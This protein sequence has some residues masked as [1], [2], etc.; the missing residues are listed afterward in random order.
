MSDRDIRVPATDDAELTPRSEGLMLAMDPALSA[1]AATRRARRI[2]ADTLPGEWDVRRLPHSGGLYQALRRQPSLQPL[3]RGVWELARRVDAHPDVL[4]AE[5]AVIQPGHDADPARVGRRGPLG[6]GGDR[7]LPCSAA[8]EWSLASARLAEA[9]SLMPGP[10]GRGIVVAH[11]DTGYT[12]H[13]EILD[14]QRLAVTL[15]YDFEADRRDPRD[16]LR[17]RSPGHGTA[18]A[19]VIMSA[20]GSADGEAGEEYE[21]GW[22]SGA[23]PAATLIP[24]RVSSGVVHFSF[25]RLALAIDHAI[26]ID[27]RDGCD[28]I[29]MSLGGPFASRSL[30]MMIGAAA[31]RGIIG[32]AAA[33]NVWPWVV[34][35]ARMP[36]VIAVAASNCRDEIWRYS[37]AGDEVDL[38]APGQDV[39]RALAERGGRYDEARSSGTSYAVATVA[40]AAALWLSRHGRDRLRRL[41]PG[42]ALPAVFRQLLTGPGVRRPP[43]WDTGRHGAG[44]LDAVGLLGARLPRRGPSSARR[45]PAAGIDTRSELARYFPERDAGDIETIIERLAG[46]GTDT[47]AFLARYGDELRFHL[48]TSPAFRAA[49]TRRGPRASRRATSAVQQHLARYASPALRETLPPV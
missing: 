28:V 3:V 44:I 23:A 41:Y 49:L 46:A 36:G 29:S 33:G 26:C 40:G 35:P 47:E 13:P 10:P 24:L 31:E 18:T 25:R 22:V 34:H 39:W 17:G 1:S 30:E 2:V 42:A 14:P 32:L 16:P 20:L 9:F 27:T 19:S 4:W 11:P 15:G 21:D 45:E 38:A 8:P 12:P 48:A 43:D 7:P 5:A 6:G 37:A